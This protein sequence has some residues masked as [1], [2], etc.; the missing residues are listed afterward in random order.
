MQHPTMPR[1]TRWVVRILRPLFMVL[2]K[3]DWRGAEKLPQGGFVLAPNHVSHLDPLFI[4]HFMVDNGVVPRFLAKD[5]LFDVPVVGSIVTNAEQIPVYRGS[6]GAAQSLR[7]A[8]QAVREGKSVTIYPEGTIT[9]DPDAWPMTGRTGA[10]R[11]ALATGAPL[12][13]MAQWGAQQILWPYTKV[14]KLFPRKTIRVRIGDPVDL[15]DLRDK[16]LTEAVL[17]EAT[18]RLMDTLTDM[19][20]EIRGERPTGPRLDVHTLKHRTH[21]Q[22]G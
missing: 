4:S 21:Y 16:P 22:E 5:T 20:V 19:L 17:H 12:V 10:V 7:A 9:R 3:R 18:N 13:P 15:S 11:V 2:M 1:A 14:P 8:E 6:A